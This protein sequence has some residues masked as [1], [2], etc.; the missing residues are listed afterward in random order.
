MDGLSPDLLSEVA[1][2]NSLAFSQVVVLAKTILDKQNESQLMPIFEKALAS[3]QYQN[4]LQV[5]HSLVKITGS[6]KN[7][8]I[9]KLIENYADDQLIAHALLS[10]LTGEEESVLQKLKNNKSHLAKSLKKAIKN[11]AQGEK[12]VLV[13]NTN[14]QTDNRTRGFLLFNTYCGTCHGMDGK[15]L[16]NLAPPLY[17]SEYVDGPSEHLILVMLNGLKGPITVHGKIYEGAAAMPG[18]KDNADITDEKIMDI[19]AYIKNGFTS[20]PEWFR[21]DGKV[22]SDLRAQTA[23]REELFTEEELLAWPIDE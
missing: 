7:E 11:K 9:D 10:S 6:A 13:M 12:K 15:G 2:P 21:L 3:S 22:V 18:L 14:D 17:Q 16:E 1:D 4:H 20:K 23:D 8:L 5:A 19:L